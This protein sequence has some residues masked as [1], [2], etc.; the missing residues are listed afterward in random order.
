MADSSPEVN[1]QR[2]YQAMANEH[3]A[4]FKPTIQLVA[5]SKKTHK[6]A[7]PNF[8]EHVGDMRTKAKKQHPKRKIHMA[9]RVS[10]EAIR[11]K[12]F[13][14]VKIPWSKV[15]AICVPARNFGDPKN[16]GVAKGDLTFYKAV[17]E[18]C[19]KYAK[20]KN[21]NAFLA[22]ALNASPFN[23]RPGDGATNSSIQGKPDAHMDET[24]ND[25]M[26][27]QTSQEFKVFDYDKL[28]ATKAKIATKKGKTNPK[29]SK[30]KVHKPQHNSSDFL[31]MKDFKNWESGFGT[32][33]KKAVK[34]VK[35]L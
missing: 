18:L 1:R 30:V 8:P 19:K 17:L 29:S 7:R 15:K 5:A 4:Q 31:N 20:S 2:T 16:G 12:I 32:T 35:K 3:A 26:T 28:K 13:S 34:W 10:W 21:L 9:H 27:P 6:M 23:L 25:K 11:E 33:I 22:K 14:K 24:N